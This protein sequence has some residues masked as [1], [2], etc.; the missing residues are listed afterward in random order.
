MFGLLDVLSDNVHPDSPARNAHT[1]IPIEG[2]I[3]CSSV[4]RKSISDSSGA[5]FSLWGFG[6]RRQKSTG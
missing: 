3:S 5:G 1:K 6:R 4:N 2:P